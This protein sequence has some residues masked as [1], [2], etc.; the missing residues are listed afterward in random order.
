M[1][2]DR[3]S[4]RNSA[5]GTEARG[6]FDSNC[7]AGRRWDKRRGEGHEGTGEWKSKK[8]RAGEREKK[9]DRGW[10]RHN[11]IGERESGRKREIETVVQ[12]IREWN[13]F[14][15][16][17]SPFLH[18]LFPVSPILRF[19]DS[20]FSV[21]QIHRFSDSVSLGTCRGLISHWRGLSTI[22]TS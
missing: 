1:G 8:R 17:D 2:R 15:F 21:S 16:S 22:V 7:G 11:R 20:L 18:S 12:W 3:E 9:R 10:G 14:Y 19:S 5:M 6:I 13:R 4:N